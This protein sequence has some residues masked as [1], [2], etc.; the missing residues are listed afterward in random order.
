M[1]WGSYKQLY[2]KLQHNLELLDL[3]STSGKF[4]EHGN[5]AVFFRKPEMAKKDASANIR[6]DHYRHY[7]E[8]R[9]RNGRIG[10]CH[11]DLKSLNIWI[12]PDC[13]SYNDTPAQHVKILMPSIL[14]PR[15][16][17]LIS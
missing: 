13:D 5:A 9:M 6:H 3:V 8:Q 15:T 7:F 1:Q 2:N 12:V 16:A 11:G 14:T 10:L 4:D 17:L